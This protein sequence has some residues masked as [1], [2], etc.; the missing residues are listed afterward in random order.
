VEPAAKIETPESA[1]EPGGRTEARSN[2][3][4]A[5]MLASAETSG[6]VRIRNMS[7]LGALIES[8]AVPPEGARVRLSRGSLLASGTI[9]WQNGSRAGVRF[10]SV[11]R[12]ADW[13]PRG[14]R[15]HQQKIDEAVHSYKLGI[16]PSSLASPE[17]RD[18]RSELLNLE[19]SLRRIAEDFARDMLVCELHLDNV[20]LIDVA[21]QTLAR[22][23]ALMD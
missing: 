1:G 6:P 15:N 5:A 11:I 4:V 17:A 16:V 3:F 19:Q 21:A 12:V 2:I 22:V 14:S 10:D 18:L 9:A 8:G 20:Q 7:P 13:L 23:A